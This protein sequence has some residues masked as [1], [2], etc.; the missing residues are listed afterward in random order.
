MMTNMEILIAMNRQMWGGMM[1][2]S[3][4]LLLHCSARRVLRILVEVKGGG[5]FL[6]FFFKTLTPTL[7]F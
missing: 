4:Q 1:L 3:H 2:G 6:V 5:C 7:H